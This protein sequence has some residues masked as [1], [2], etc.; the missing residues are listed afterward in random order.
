MSDVVFRS[1]PE[2]K[3]DAPNI[4]LPDQEVDKTHAISGES[5][6][7]PIELREESGGSIVLDALNISDS[8]QVLPADD[9][10]K[11]SE[12]KEY[13]LKIMESKGLGETVGA[14]KK[15]LSEVK[16]EMGLDQEAEPSIVLDRIAGVVRSWRNLSFL[17]DPTQKKSVFMKLA[18]MKS[19]EEMNKEVYRLMNEYKV[20]R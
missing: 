15:V 20:W 7:E 16:G 8:L 6:I 5:D 14:F 12:V 1:A 10:A 11:V 9:K 17:T 19:S 3:A 2:P 18:N 13:V 4:P